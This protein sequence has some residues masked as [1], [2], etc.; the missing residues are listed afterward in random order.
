MIPKYT[1]PLQQQNVQSKSRHQGCTQPKSKNK[2]EKEK[3]DPAESI[4]CSQQQTT[5]IDNT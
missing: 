3:I 5:T 4:R 1:Q 2:K